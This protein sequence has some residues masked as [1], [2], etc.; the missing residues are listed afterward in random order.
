MQGANQN[1]KIGYYGPMPPT[2]KPHG[3]HFQI[4]ALDKHL[5]LP[6]GFNRQAL[7]DAIKGHVIAK[8]KFVGIYQR[9]PDVRNKK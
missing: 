4:F 7:L 2:D 9:K 5:D 8:G 6:G 3:Y 1:G